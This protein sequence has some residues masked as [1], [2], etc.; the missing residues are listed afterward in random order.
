MNGS[1]LLLSSDTFLGGFFFQK[2]QSHLSKIRFLDLSF[3]EKKSAPDS[4]DSTV[5]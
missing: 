5:L 4:Y 1:H 3:K 2:I